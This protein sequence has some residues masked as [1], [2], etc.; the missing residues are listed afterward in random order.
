MKMR[1]S[2]LHLLFSAVLLVT[3]LLSAPA[4]AAAQLTKLRASYAG[5][6]GY[7]LPMCK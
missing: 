7:H 2:I 6:T 5:T 4:P 1:S 3:A